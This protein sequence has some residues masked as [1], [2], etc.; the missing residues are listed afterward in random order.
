MRW[1]APILLVACSKGGLDPNEKVPDFALP[2]VNETSSRYQTEVSP[3]D[4]LQQVSGWYF[5]HAT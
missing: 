4:L 1:L 2:D 3:R 5:G